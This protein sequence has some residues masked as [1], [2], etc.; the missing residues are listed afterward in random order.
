MGFGQWEVNN[1]ASIRLSATERDLN[2]RER[3]DKK[4]R[5]NMPDVVL[6]EEEL[7]IQ[8]RLHREG[9]LRRPQRRLGW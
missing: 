5:P 6:Q 4:E 9:D 1:A 8:S 7:E 3:Q 2:L